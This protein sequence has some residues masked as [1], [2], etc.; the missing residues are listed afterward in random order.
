[1]HH[2]HVRFAEAAAQLPRPDGK[3]FVELL[4]HGTLSVELYAPRGQDPQK[5]HS[6]D[7]LYLVM[8][9]SGLFARGAERVPFSAGD[10]LFVPAH[11][12]HRFVDFTDDLQVWVVFYGPESGEKA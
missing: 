2:W 10:V 7:E 8:H 9:G 1:M 12:E 3:R 6:R 11:L 4:K 5:P